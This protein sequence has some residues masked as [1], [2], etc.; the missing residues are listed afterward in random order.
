MGAIGGS[1]STMRFSRG[2]RG[3][4]GNEIERNFGARIEMARRDITR[5]CRARFAGQYFN[6]LGAAEIT[7]LPIASPEPATHGVVEGQTVR[8]ELLI[9]ALEQFL[10]FDGR[11]RRR[12]GFAG[13]LDK[14]FSQPREDSLAHDPCL[15]MTE[16]SYISDDCGSTCVKERAL[17]TWK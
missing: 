8:L 14:F 16:R 11:I 2:L 15:R 9:D 7:A 3:T 6:A 13:Q 12:F 1:Y 10:R 5:A 4:H 17:K